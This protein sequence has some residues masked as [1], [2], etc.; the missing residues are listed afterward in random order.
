LGRRLLVEVSARGLK[1]YVLM[2]IFY[3]AAGTRQFVTNDRARGPR[4]PE[5]QRGAGETAGQIKERELQRSAG[6]LGP[7]GVATLAAA[8][9]AFVLVATAAVLATPALG[10]CPNE[11]SRVGASVNLPDCRAYELTTP[12]LNGAAPSD[13]PA[14]SVEGVRADGSALAFVATDAPANAEG[15]TATATTILAARSAGGWSTR[16]L[17]APTP[18]ASGTYFGDASSTVGLSADLTQSVLWSNQP[19]TPA[20][21]VGTNLYLR[22]ANGSFVALTK[23]GAPAFGPGGALSGASLDFSRLFITTTVKQLDEDP[24]LNGN[25]YEFSNGQLHLVTILPESSGEEPA[26]AGGALA[27]GVL[28]SVSDDGHHVIF[29]A[30]LYPGLYLRSDGTKS[31]EVSKS[32]RTPPNVN[33]PAEAI[34]A[35]IAADGSEVLFVSA[36]ELTDDA[37]TGESGGLPNDAG[38]D[39]YSYD[40]VSG[41]LT[42]LTVDTNPADVATGA[43]VEAVLGASPDASYIYFV[44]RG[45]LASG[46]TSGERNLYVEH[47]GTIDYV[48]TDP[49]ADAHF[50][51]TPDGLH[52]GFTSTAPQGAYDNAGFAEVYRYTYGGALECASCRPSNAAPSA[53]ASIVGRALSD[54]GARLFFQSADGILPT[55]QSGQANVFEYSGGEPR[56]L[57]PGD[58]AAALLVGADASGDDVFIAT[59][60]ELSPQGQGPVFAIYDARVN[61]QVPVPNVPA[62]CQGEGCRGALP[63]APEF[64]GAG[65][66]SFE[67]PGRV[68]APALKVVK[69]SKL[70]LRLI[71]PGA[72]ELTVSGRGLG[73]VKKQA[74]K[75]GAATVSMS[76]KP[77]AERKRQK[78]GVFRTEA[79]ILFRSA[80]GEASRA[81]VE[82]GF[83]ATSKRVKGDR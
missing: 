12:G 22:R 68:S 16:S 3:V 29:K 27:Q 54:D 81:S 14:I 18:L 82:L 57:T 26:P 71:V 70:Q 35:G 46:A 58:G 63:A 38:A 80:S 51:V 2:P 30:N 21:P 23:V 64:P 77:G 48:A 78:R 31:V 62:E 75:A 45:N 65:S 61:A 37:N 34:P 49:Q 25:T 55:A 7:I 40:V 60:Q 59:F 6:L 33:P 13:W 50:Y 53:D 47:N 11:A 10:A 36:S 74:A 5:Q 20:A 52:A 43:D 41:D 42:D 8:I 15:S 9:S 19:L 24:L 17:S 79:E 67:A 4:S 56:L 39:L 83:E 76:L 69:G 44:A 73:S 32:Q 28:P 1:K 66:A 72:G